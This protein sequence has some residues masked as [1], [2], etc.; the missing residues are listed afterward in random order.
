M[1]RHISLTPSFQFLTFQ[2]HLFEAQQAHAV[3]LT[4]LRL[5]TRTIR[6]K[7]IGEAN[8]PILT[9]RR[10]N[11]YLLRW[12]RGLLLLSLFSLV[13][14][15]RWFSDV[16]HVSVLY[17]TSASSATILLWRCRSS[18][19][20]DRSMKFLRIASFGK[21]YR[22]LVWWRH[23]HLFSVCAGLVKPKVQIFI[24]FRSGECI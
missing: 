4:S 10:Q 9:K 24:Y 2:N 7:P 3:H 15:C 13:V 18:N 20:R 12:N 6:L 23:F 21:L 1:T 22:S 5:P 19:L 17:A 16:L 14:Q 11:R 8:N